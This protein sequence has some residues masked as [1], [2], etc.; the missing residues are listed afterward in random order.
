MASISCLILWVDIEI[1]V[2]FSATW[3][4][5][6]RPI[7]FLASEKPNLINFQAKQRN[8]LRWVCSA[9][10]PIESQPPSAS[11]RFRSGISLNLN[12]NR[13]GACLG[14]RDEIDTGIRRHWRRLNTEL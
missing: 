14:V 11:T 8:Y 7:E 10:P 12:S 6:G 2:Y 5:L 9:H 4:L 3:P 1:E 13:F